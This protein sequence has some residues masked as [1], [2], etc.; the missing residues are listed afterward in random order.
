MA[1]V[2]C[3][4]EM[5]MGVGLRSPHRPLSAT[6]DGAQNSRMPYLSEA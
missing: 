2:R 5:G 3:M 4:T 6:Q 1:L